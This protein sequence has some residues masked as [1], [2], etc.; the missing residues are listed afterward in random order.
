MIKSTGSEYGC[1]RLLNSAVNEFLRRRG[2]G[3]CAAVVGMA[4]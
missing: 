1:R 4:A 2:I 3:R